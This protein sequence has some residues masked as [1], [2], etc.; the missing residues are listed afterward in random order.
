MQCLGRW[1]ATLQQS[2]WPEEVRE[3]ILSDYDSPDHNE[4]AATQSTSTVGDRRNEIVFIGPGIGSLDSQS[5]LKDALDA[6]LLNDE[7]WDVFRC[8][9][10]DEASLAYFENPLQTRMLTY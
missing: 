6:C 2:Q 7:E 10:D 1:W 8:K 4:A 9:R 3:S 5:A